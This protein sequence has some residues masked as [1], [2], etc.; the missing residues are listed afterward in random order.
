MTKRGHTSIDRRLIEALR[1][2]AERGPD[3]AVQARVFSRLEHRIAGLGAAAAGSTIGAAAAASPVAK[4]LLVSLLMHPV[5]VAV[6]AAAVG[7][8]ATGTIVAVQDASPN[9]PPAQHAASTPMCAS[10]RP[11]PVPAPAPSAPV[12][13]PPEPVATP[14]IAPQRARQ[15]RLVAPVGAGAPTNNETAAPSP[16]SLSEQQALLDD[17]R[18]SLARGENQAVLDALE[19]HGHR[20]PE[21]DLT[22]E[23]EALAIK[24]LVAAGQPAAA[25][26]RGARFKQ[27]FPNSLLLPSVTQTLEAIP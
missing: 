12:L 18:R 27:R 8:V 4:P 15:V 23:R 16:A 19:S 2:D 14:Q 25:R 7:G 1:A 9:E 10:V 21:S 17:A 3:A 20:Y 6:V 22:E 24:A 5:G 11:I 13:A 26:E